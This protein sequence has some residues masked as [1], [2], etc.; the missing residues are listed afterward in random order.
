MLVEGTYTARFHRTFSAELCTAYFLRTDDVTFT[1]Q[2]IKAGSASY[3]L[4]GEI[5]G[6]AT[7]APV[8]DISLT[9]GAGAFFP[10]PGQVFVSNAKIK[11]L[12]SLGLMIAF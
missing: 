2:D 8:S 5:Y 3:L 11:W 4:G 6:G 10:Q 12:I 9:A 1:D 7:W